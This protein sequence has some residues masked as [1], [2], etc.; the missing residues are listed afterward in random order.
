VKI[1]TKN[2][3][4]A[5]LTKGLSRHLYAKEGRNSIAVQHGVI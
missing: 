1:E 3:L 2:Q 5:I 4:T